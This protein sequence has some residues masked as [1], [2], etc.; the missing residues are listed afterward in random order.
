MKPIQTLIEEVP[1]WRQLT[2][3]EI[4]ARLEQKTVH[5]VDPKTY[6]LVDIAKLIG[7]ENMPAFLKVVKDSGYDWMITEAASGVRLGDD[8]INTRL[9][10]L[11]H[12]VALTLANHTNRMVSLLEQNNSTTTVEEVAAVQASLLLEIY[13]HTKIDGYQ[14]QLQ[15]YREALTVWDGTPETEPRF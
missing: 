11:N 12:P 15:A 10:L 2:P 14:D 8:P 13:K 1:N 5:Y 9:R 4:L 6:R 7:D 3:Q